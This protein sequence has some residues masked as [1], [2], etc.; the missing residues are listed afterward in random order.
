MGCTNS[1]IDACPSLRK[2][3]VS[4]GRKAKAAAI[5]VTLE[6]F[7]FPWEPSRDTIDVIC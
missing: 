5:Y 3:G 7:M 1:K 2:N 6:E 4:K